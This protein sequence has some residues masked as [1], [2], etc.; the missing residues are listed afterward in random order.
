MKKREKEEPKNNKQ[1]ENKKF[2]RLKHTTDTP[3]ESINVL[4]NGDSIYSLGYETNNPDCG[5]QKG[6]LLSLDKLLGVFENVQ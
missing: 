5:P 6:K 3:Y 4:E 1:Y 2:P